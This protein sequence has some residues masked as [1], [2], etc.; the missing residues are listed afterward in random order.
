[1]ANSLHEIGTFV[2]IIGLYQVS[3]AYNY[4][5]EG[6]MEGFRSPKMHTHIYCSILEY[7]STMIF[8][9][10]GRKSSR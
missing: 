1:M 3:F 6:S 5:I 8:P 10:R 9:K 2:P 7:A 4:K